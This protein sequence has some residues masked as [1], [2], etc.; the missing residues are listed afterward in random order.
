MKTLLLLIL[1]TLLLSVKAPAKQ[2][3]QQAVYIC[4]PCNSS[5]DSAEF[6]EAGT[7]KICGM[8]LEVK[9]ASQSI[10]PNGT[11]VR[12]QRSVAILLFPGVQIIDYTA[13]WEVFGQARWRVFSVA[14]TRDTITTS[15]NM[16]VI[17][18]Y[19]LTDHPKADII[20]IPGG[21]VTAN[22]TREPI[23]QWIK[24]Q[25]ETA[26]IVMSVCN[27]A[28]FLG[29]AGLLDGKEATTFAGLIPGLQNI[30]PKAKVV[31]NKRFCDNGKI[32]TSAGLSSGIDAALHVV[33]RIQSRTWASVVA[34]NLEYNWDPNSKY[35]RALLADVAIGDLWNVYQP[36][37]RELVDDHGTVNEWNT[38]INL[39]SPVSPKEFM[40]HALETVP[41]WKVI[42]RGEGTI[43]WEYADDS[44]KNWQVELAATKK[45]DK[46]GTS[47][48]IKAK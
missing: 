46:L 27:G 25:N 10:Q 4:P 40:D 48:L 37:D 43:R 23:L 19:T 28:Y 18:D 30:A 36:Y 24:R 41:T 31:R 21:N 17:P 9:K 3:V 44:G 12:E 7:C 1:G 45:D 34:T 15:M 16:R 29:K 35:A 11:F 22:L 6:L 32:I 39:L 5:C 47:I 42:S 38:K 8:K 13:P 33:E 20:V 2:S 26:E 14:E